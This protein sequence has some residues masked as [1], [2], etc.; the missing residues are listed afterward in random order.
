MVTRCNISLWEGPVPSEEQLQAPKGRQIAEKR[1]YPVERVQSILAKG[2]EHVVL[3]T[4]G[5]RD[6]VS[7]RLWDTEDVLELLQHA[8]ISGKAVRPEWCAAM[9]TGPLAACDVYIV[10]RK[11][12]HPVTGRD[13]LMQ[14][15]LKFAIAK[16]EKVVL[17]VSCHT[18][19]R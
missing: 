2:A 7:A 17:V 9:P 13:I 5:C 15:Y 11:E 1:L 14:Y 6:D 18:T 19:E 8:L 4:K 16:T 12:R 10:Y 3:W